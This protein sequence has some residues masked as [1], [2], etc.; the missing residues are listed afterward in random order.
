[1]SGIK[2]GGVACEKT[3][4]TKFRKVLKYRINCDNITLSNLTVKR[5]TK[6]VY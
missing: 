5:R 3:L 4:I 6:N 2:N 1:M